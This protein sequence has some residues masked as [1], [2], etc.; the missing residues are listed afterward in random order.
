MATGFIEDII[1]MRRLLLFTIMMTALGMTPANESTYD[2]VV[3]G[4]SCS[5]TTD[6]GPP[7]HQLDCSY[8]VG[9]DLLFVIAGVG[10]TDVAITVL[11]AN[12]FDADY[13]F[14][15]GVAHG[16]VIVKPGTAAAKAAIA[17]GR[18]P[19]PAFVSPKDGGVYRTWSA[20]K[21]A[22]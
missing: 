17:A 19:E 7:S 4:K 21:A 8:Q 9:H 16:C 6:L 18:A 1:M 3:R 2:A 5:R 20:C 12:G 14:T 15:F 11:K 10:Q 13:F 22:R